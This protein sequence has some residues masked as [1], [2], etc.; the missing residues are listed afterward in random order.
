[1]LENRPED[2]THP[3]GNRVLECLEFSRE[4]MLLEGAPRFDKFRATL[5]IPQNG[6]RVDAD[7][8]VVNKKDN[9]FEVKFVSPSER[10]TSMLSWWDSEDRPAPQPSLDQNAGIDA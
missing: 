1:M 4:G 5:S 8:V 6:E 9:A 2:S 10:L 7:V 3:Q